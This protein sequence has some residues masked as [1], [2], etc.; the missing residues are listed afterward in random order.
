VSNVQNV[1]T[2]QDINICLMM[3][4]QR[5]KNTIHKWSAKEI[6]SICQVHPNSIMHGMDP[7]RF[8]AIGNRPT[9]TVTGVD[10]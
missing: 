6:Q 4:I 2:K 9:V 7:D 3:Q 5:G 1:F 8:S 10:A